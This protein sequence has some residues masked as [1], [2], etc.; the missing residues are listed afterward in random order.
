MQNNDLKTFKSI[1]SHLKLFNIRTILAH[2]RSWYGIITPFLLSV[3]IFIISSLFPKT[4]SCPC[5]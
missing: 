1:E 2:R 3:Y 5:S 4:R